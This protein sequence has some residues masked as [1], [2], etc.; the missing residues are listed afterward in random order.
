M[1]EQA[2]Y[3]HLIAQ[4]DLAQYLTT[5]NGIPAVF[6]QEAP[7]D[8]DALWGDGPQY[9]RI[10]FAVDIKGDPE[11]TMGGT[12]VVDI[13]CKENEQFPEVLEP[14]VRELIH[15][16]FFS[17][18][19][20]TVEAQWKTSSYFTQPTDKVT[21]CTIV[22]ELLAFPLMTTGSPDVI[23][24]INEWTAAIDGISVIN[25]DTLPSTAWKPEGTDSAVY[26][27]LVDDSPAVWIPDTFQTI[28]RTSTIRG[29]IF[30]ADH[31]TA[32]TVA[33]NLITQLYTDKRLIKTGESP[34]MVN[35]NNKIST[36]ADPL[37]AGQVT[38]EATYGIIVFT[39]PDTDL[40][41]IDVKIDFN[42]EESDQWLPITN[43]P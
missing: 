18:G 3:E 29:H 36:G 2:L 42:G 35:Q 40:T 24:R 7:A 14:I 4:A 38:V 32:D 11:R 20:F 31:A 21:G 6:N 43:E 12:L 5:Y 23:A 19:T 25:Y 22:F 13:Q 8:V 33:R 34:I 39:E 9:G 17:N 10:V 30:S 1:I 15:G 26:W 41:N 37:R 28:W 27:R 16:W